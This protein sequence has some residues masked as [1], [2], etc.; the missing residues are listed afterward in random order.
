MAA[1]A[2][3]APLV[4]RRNEILYFEDAIARACAGRGSVVHIGGEPGV[5]K[6]RLAEHVLQMAA[7]AGTHASF[8]RCYETAAKPPFIGF[9]GNRQRSARRIEPERLGAL[10]GDRAPEVCR[11]VP[12]LG[13]LVPGTPSLPE[14]PPEQQR[15]NVF[16][17]FLEFLNRWSRWQPLVLLLDDLHAADPGTLDLLDH[18][19]DHVPSMPVLLMGTYRDNELPSHPRFARVLEDG[20][21]KGLMDIVAL[22]RFDK[23]DVREMIRSRTSRLPS[24]STT[25]H[26]LRFTDG[27]PFY[28]EEVLRTLGTEVL[29]PKANTTGWRPESVASSPRTGSLGRA[30]SASLCFRPPPP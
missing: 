5:G 20:A 16:N 14:L 23:A 26:V 17:G 25:E 2:A 12:E 24:E 9:I 4:G 13:R 27:N 8:G 19:A 15:R 21:R 1:Y 6:T 28:V 7:R 11:L 18:L 29:G 30:P 22:K 3:E 10:L